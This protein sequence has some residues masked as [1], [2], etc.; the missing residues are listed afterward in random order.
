MNLTSSQTKYTV[1]FP[2]SAELVLLVVV[3][4][5]RKV[6]VFVVFVLLELLEFVLVV[7]VVLAVLVVL[8]GELPGRK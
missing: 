8:E 2:V 6:V 5:A 4:L 1:S 7:L 3:S